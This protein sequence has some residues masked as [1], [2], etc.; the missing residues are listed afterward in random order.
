MYIHIVP[1]LTILAFRVRLCW[2]G[3]NTI[4]DVKIRH[5]KQGIIILRD[6]KIYA[7]TY[8][9]TQLRTM[10]SYVKLTSCPSETHLILTWW[11]HQ[12]ESFSALLIFCAGNSPVTGTL[13]FSLI[14]TSTN[15]HEFKMNFL[16]LFRV[17]GSYQ[18]YLLPQLPW[19]APGPI[20]QTVYELMIDILWEISSL[21]LRF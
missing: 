9:W 15:G 13:M 18:L 5:I 8:V 19:E 4:Q 10:K 12:M 20:S 11:R 17:N 3:K 7:N 16:F 14:F 21:H 6:I 2:L 1:D